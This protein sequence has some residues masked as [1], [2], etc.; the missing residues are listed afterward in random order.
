MA[1]SVDMSS[2]AGAEVGNL[3]ET[4]LEG[5]PVLIELEQQLPQRL[6]VRSPCHSPG[7]NCRVGVYAECE[8]HQLSYA[9]C[10]IQIVLQGSDKLLHFVRRL[11]QQLTCLLYFDRRLRRWTTDTNVLNA[12]LT[13]GIGL[14]WLTLWLWLLTLSAVPI[15]VE[16]VVDERLQQSL[17][18]S[19]TGTVLCG[20]GT[21]QHPEHCRQEGD[22]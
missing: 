18:N 16:L 1:N 2:G 6:D 14:S 15:I 9:R 17:D 20:G 13:H 19:Q 10:P 11:G 22:S 5:M 4:V 21:G 12:G 7:E 3:R 8:R